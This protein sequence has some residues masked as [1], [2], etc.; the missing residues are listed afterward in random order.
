MYKEVKT[1]AQTYT[2][3]ETEIPMKMLKK[4]NQ[5]TIVVRQKHLSLYGVVVS[6]YTD[7]PPTPIP[8]S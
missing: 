7:R 2:T 6:Y 1:K 5:E 4:I 8:S 3:P